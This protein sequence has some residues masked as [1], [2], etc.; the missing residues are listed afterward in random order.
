VDKL[1]GQF[2]GKG[3]KEHRNRDRRDQFVIATPDGLQDV[4]R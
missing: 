3:N 1:A 4:L 2:K